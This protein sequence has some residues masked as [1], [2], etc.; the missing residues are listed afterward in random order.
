MYASK[1]RQCEADLTGGLIEVPIVETPNQSRPD[2]NSHRVFAF[3]AGILFAGLTLWS[4]IL[5]ISDFF[6][7]RWLVKMGMV[8]FAMALLCFFIAFNEE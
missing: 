5:L 1:C 3:F 8:L 4:L 2:Y 7:N 6:A